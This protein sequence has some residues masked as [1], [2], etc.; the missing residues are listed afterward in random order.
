V[1]NL[2]DMYAAFDQIRE[3]A[4]APG[5]RLVAGHDPLVTRRLCQLA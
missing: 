1:A 2:A 5:A 3:L 4:S